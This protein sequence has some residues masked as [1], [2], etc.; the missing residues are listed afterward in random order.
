MNPSQFQGLNCCNLRNWWGGGDP[1]PEATL[2]LYNSV[3]RPILQTASVIR[4]VPPHDLAV[5]R[6]YQAYQLFKSLIK[7]RNRSISVCCF[8]FWAF[9][10][11][12]ASTSTAVSLV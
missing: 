2:T 11:L 6:K 3:G 8:S 4:C 12:T 10:S 5:Y 1:V 7:T 9:N